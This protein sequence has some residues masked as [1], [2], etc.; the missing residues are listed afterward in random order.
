MNK[1]PFS[2]YKELAAKQGL[3]ISSIKDFENKIYWRGL[4]NET[5]KEVFVEKYY[6]RFAFDP[7][8]CHQKF[9]LKFIERHIDAGN[10][11]Y[12]S[13]IQK[14]TEAFMHKHA[15][16]LD[17]GYLL[18]FQKMSEQFILE[19]QKYYKPNDLEQIADNPKI[20]LSD[21]FLEKHKQIDIC[22]YALNHKVS[23]SFLQ[24][25]ANRIV[26]QNKKHKFTGSIFNLGYRLAV[27]EA[28]HFLYKTTELQL[29]K[30]KV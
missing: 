13:Q 1:I 12:I 25:F 4:F 21:A 5:L 2:Y 19:H 24:K 28:K 17:W 18:R 7:L 16:M 23:D 3:K 29:K 15:N 10:A 11:Q 14:L 27:V 22:S 30:D 8:S 26:R 9:S 20:N 6:V